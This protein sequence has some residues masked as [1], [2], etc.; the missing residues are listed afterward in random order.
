M[1]TQ[2]VAHQDDL[3]HGTPCIALRMVRRLYSVYVH[4]HTTSYAAMI[5]VDTPI[6]KKFHESGWFSLDRIC[7]S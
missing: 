3:P 1:H 5:I 6:S 4:A 2:S 7:R